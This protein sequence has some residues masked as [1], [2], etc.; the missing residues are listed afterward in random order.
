MIIP[1]R[2]MAKN[3]ANKTKKK[4]ISWSGECVVHKNFNEAQISIYKKYL[5][6]LKILVHIE[7][8]PEIVHYADYSGST[9]GIKKYV[10]DNPKSKEFLIMTECG[11]LGTLKEEFPDRNFYTPCT[12]CPYMKK[13]TFE[14][15]VWGLRTN[16][17]EVKI[18]ENTRVK[19]Q[20]ALNRM[21]EYS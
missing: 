3:I 4:I 20:K 17:Y 19:A 21:F 1:D 16:N 18:P 14:N 6:K 5:P 8:S 11:M 13:I 7:C 2:Y 15:L 9:S 12:I 10:K